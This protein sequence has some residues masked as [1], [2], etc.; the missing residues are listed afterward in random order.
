MNKK[1]K[2]EKLKRKEDEEEKEEV[3]EEITLV[4]LYNTCC[5]NI[6]K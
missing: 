2:L 1:T 6:K 4:K 3:E 5:T